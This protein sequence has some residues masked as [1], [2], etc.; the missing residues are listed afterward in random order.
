MTEEVRLRFE[1]RYVFLLSICLAIVLSFPWIYAHLVA[2][3]GSSYSGFE[4]ATDDQMVYAAWMKQASMGHFFFDNRFAIEP[5]P[6][7]TVNVF[8]FALGLLS[9]VLTIPVAAHA[10][11]IGL[12][13]L[14]VY[15]LH[16][17]IRRV[18]KDVY[19]TKLA[20]TLAVV[21]GGLGFLVWHNFGQAFTDKSTPLASIGPLLGNQLP[22]DVW[23]TEGF[24]FSSM[25]TTPLFVAAL[26]LIVYCFTC[27]ID[28]RD[29]WKPVL[30]GAIAFGVLM[31]IHSYDALLITIVMVGFLVA[32]VAN[33]TLTRVW[34]GRALMIGSG[35]IPAALWFLH[36]L[37]EDP[38]FQARA[39][40]LTY[41]PNF[42]QVL[43]GYLLM[44]GLAFAGIAARRKEKRTVAGLVLLGAM[45]VGLWILAM[46]PY[47]GYF[48]SMPLWVIVIG[49]GLGVVWCLAEEEPA[50]NLL[51]SWAVL[52]LVAPYF[53]AIF[54]RKLTMGLSIPWAILAAL[55]L[56]AAGAKLERQ[57]RNLITVLGLVLLSATSLFWVLLRERTLISDN[58]SNTT[59]H[60][61]FLTSNENQII[62]Y[63]GG[64]SD[65]RVVVLARP[66]I[67]SPAAGQDGNAIPD[68][69]Q[70]P[71]LA[72]LNPFLTGFSGV[73]TYAGHWSETPD[74][75]Q[76]RVEEA[77]F[78]DE[79]ASADERA[80]L[81][82][83]S[84]SKF[85]VAPVPEAF[86]DLKLADL[87]RL[88]VVV[89]DGP[90]FRLI[91]LP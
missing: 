53:P 75:D 73:Y 84:G 54:Q 41:S 30:P 64:L 40:T 32:A 59:V 86:P 78:F 45:C 50:W 89:V 14:L 63:L 74:Y 12:S 80:T 15:L 58:V 48:L 35:A 33:K 7:L 1:K 39:A 37:K 36:V 81:I 83:K 25:L 66:G 46:Q 65:A 49:C 67:P 22:T 26:C 79:R 28:A 2:P 71:Y 34:V 85:V 24:V 29:G 90:Q 38:V 55:G 56:A 13:I 61:V 10:A 23:Q 27:F 72:D 5:Q 87:R 43:F 91:K 16:G 17:L 82:Q 31:N 4:F 3:A 11:R 20:L 19:T 52:G 44:V 68:T 77:H 42:R 62:A 6:G 47:Q 9:R 8:F 70:T 76:R 69:W 88:G 51:V 57:S 21:G 60:P 18:T